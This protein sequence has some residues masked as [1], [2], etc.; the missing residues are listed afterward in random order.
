MQHS[1]EQCA[2]TTDVLSSFHDTPKEASHSSNAGILY[3]GG[4]LA[5]FCGVI[6]GCI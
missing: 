2:G 5:H 1:P 6:H 4:T 3:G